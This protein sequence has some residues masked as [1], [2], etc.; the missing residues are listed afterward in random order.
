MERNDQRALWNR[1]TEREFEV[2]RLEREQM[3]AAYERL[4]PEVIA[5]L[6][7]STSRAPGSHPLEAEVPC[8]ERARC[9]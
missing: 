5:R 2:S 4:L 7:R 9:A 1:R 6:A 8:E 3:A